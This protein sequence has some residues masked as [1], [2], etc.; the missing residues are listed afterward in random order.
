MDLSISH[1]LATETDRF[2]SLPDLEA[3]IYL[4]GYDPLVPVS[5]VVIP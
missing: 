2:L 3:A 1:D 5:I 4:G